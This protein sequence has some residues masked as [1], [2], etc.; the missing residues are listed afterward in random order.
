MNE[1][2]NKNTGN[3]GAEADDAREEDIVKDVDADTKDVEGTEDAGFDKT[4]ARFSG[5]EATLEKILGELSSLREAQGIMVENGAVVHD[6]DTDLGHVEEDEFDPN[7][8][9]DLLIK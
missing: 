9:M 1:N 7:A 8:V 3:D 6:V 2:D 5:I 4:E